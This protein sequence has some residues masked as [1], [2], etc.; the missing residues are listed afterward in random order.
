MYT[1]LACILNSNYLELSSRLTPFIR[2]IPFF[3]A[4]PQNTLLPSSF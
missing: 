4:A 2:N 1:E 3:Q